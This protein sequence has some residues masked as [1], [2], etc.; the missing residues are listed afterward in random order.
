MGRAEKQLTEEKNS[1]LTCREAIE[2]KEM[3]RQPRPVGGPI[4]HTNDFYIPIIAR[5]GYKKRVKGFEP[6]AFSLGS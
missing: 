2:D 5:P 1:E 6:L 3:S 4:D